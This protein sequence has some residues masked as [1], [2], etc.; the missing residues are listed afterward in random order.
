MSFRLFTRSYDIYFQLRS[1]SQIETVLVSLRMRTKRKNGCVSRAETQAHDETSSCCQFM[2]TNNAV[3][4][5]TNKINQPNPLN[6]LPDDQQQTNPAIPVFSNERS[7]RTNNQRGSNYVSHP[8]NKITQ[9]TNKSINQPS[10]QPTILPSIHLTNQ[11]SN[12]S[13]DYIFKYPPN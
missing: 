8:T 3:T 2:A 6:Q 12:Y 4:A 13:T 10:T 11:L 5:E 1:S 7:D 9:P